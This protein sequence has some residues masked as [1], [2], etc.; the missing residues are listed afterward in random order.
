MK[1]LSIHP[2][3]ATILSIRGITSCEAAAAFLAP[4]LSDMIDPALLMGMSTAVDRLMQAR[5]RQESL[6]IYGDYDVDGIAGTS[7]L[8]SFLRA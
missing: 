1:G 6:C 7:L 4:K 2:V 5:K 3:T 8:V